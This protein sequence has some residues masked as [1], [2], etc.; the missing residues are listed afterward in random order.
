M[1]EPLA[2]ALFVKNV[3]KKPESRSQHLNS[4]EKLILPVYLLGTHDVVVVKELPEIFEFELSVFCEEKTDST[5]PFVFQ[6]T[7]RT[8]PSVKWPHV[9]RP[10]VTCCI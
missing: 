5:R 1:A 6:V 4:L 10:A 7:H 2:F 3:P 9:S 8:L